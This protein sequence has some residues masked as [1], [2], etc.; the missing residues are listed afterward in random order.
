MAKTLL[1][2]EQI[3]DEVSKRVRDGSGNDPMQ[4]SIPLPKPHPTDAEERNW[5]METVGQ[6]GHDAYV[7]RVIEDARREFL[8]SDEAERDEAFGDSIAHP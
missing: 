4:V 2:A 3:R 5:D 1:T 8:L 7:R 6:P